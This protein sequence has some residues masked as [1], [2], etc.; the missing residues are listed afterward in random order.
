MDDLRIARHRFD[1]SRGDVSGIRVHQTQPA[2]SVNFTT[3]A[4]HQ[5]LRIIDPKAAAVIDHRNLRRT[6]RALEVI[7]STG[8][9]F[10]DQRQSGKEAYDLLQLGLRR[11]RA[12]LYERID[13]RI[14]QMLAEGLVE[15]VQSLL[16]RGYEPSLPS[17]SAIGYREIIAYLQGKISLEDA[18]REMRHNTRVFVRRQANWF[19][20]NDPQIHWFSYTPTVAGEMESEIR[21]WLERGKSN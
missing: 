12:E 18:V 6:I 9:R 11:P 17:L 20:A 3:E 10:S 19:K 1:E 14:D 16:K 7:L 13:A 2:Q 4:L 8:K 21:T 15:E 5:R